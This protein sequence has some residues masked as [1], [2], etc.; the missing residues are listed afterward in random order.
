VAPL[1]QCETLERI[2]CP[3]ME[4][5]G[6]LRRLP[7]LQRLSTRTENGRIAQSAKAFW[8]EFDEKQK[9]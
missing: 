3:P 7:R 1:A 5:V 6:T 9:P 4:G 8:A 2:N